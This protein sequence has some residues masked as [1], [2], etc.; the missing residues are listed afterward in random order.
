MRK[1]F[2]TLSSLPEPRIG[3]VMM[4]KN[5]EKRLS[6]SLESIIGTV[7]ALIIYDT[8]STDNT[9]KIV[10]DF[11]E[12]NKI[13][14]YLIQGEFVDFATSRNVVLD[15]A[16]TIDV[17]FLLLL[18]CND[19]L[20]NGEGL[21]KFANAMF[22]EKYTGFLTCQQW[23][24]GALDKYYNIRFVRNKSGWRYRGSVH[25][26]MKDTTSTTDAPTHPIYR[27]PDDIVLYQDRSKDD[28]KSLKRFN[29]DKVL[30]LEEFKKNP[31][32]PRTLFYLAQTCGS[33]NQFDESLYYNKL[34]LEL[35][36]FEEEKFHAYL[37]CGDCALQLRHEWQD[38]MAW[39]M[40]AF[41]HSMRAE[42]LSKIGDYYIH[43]AS[44]E[45]ETKGNKA[46]N[47]WTLAY[48]FI[49]QACELKYP[50]DA[51]LFVDR[52]VYIYY[53][54]YQMG[55]IG[56]YVGKFQEGRDA[57][58]IAIKESP[59][60]T[61]KTVNQN[62]LKIYDDVMNKIK[63][64]ETKNQLEELKKKFPNESLRNLKKRLN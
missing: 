9:I 6:V 42:P 20:K 58:I 25:E 32:E 62:N 40:K 38:V 63:D 57:C 41:H 56:F 26:W 59:N 27:M 55:R 3:L 53:R 13:N 5:E 37:R 35:D 50:E 47:Y 21:K 16:D 33:L 60:E 1:E 34:R 4:L 52:G 30:L 45:M 46:S 43:K 23:F 2:Y 14:L 11:S 64:I 19:E 39:Y 12:K 22:K 17:N 54:W 18:D 48:M 28:N 31:S 24:S 44:L 29:R 7:S 10:S 51:I 36:G 61:M 8:G 15:Y 49:K